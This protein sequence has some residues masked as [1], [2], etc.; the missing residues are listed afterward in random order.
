MQTNPAQYHRNS[1]HWHK[2]LGNMGVVI[3][4]TQLEVTSPEFEIFLP[5]CFLI[6]KLDS[7]K[8]IEIVGEANTVFESGDQVILEL[9]K[10]A[11]VNSSDILSYGL[12]ACKVANDA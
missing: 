1:K 11:D 7:G 3:H 10:N 6:V 5:Y 8:K 12:K 2:L 9:R 4:S